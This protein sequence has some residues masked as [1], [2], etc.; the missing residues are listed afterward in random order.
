MIKLVQRFENYPTATQREI[1]YD[2]TIPELYVDLLH[3]TPLHWELDQKHKRWP[4]TP[5]S[6]VTVNVVIMTVQNYCA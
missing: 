2:W 5:L 1:S 6:K 4:K 3:M